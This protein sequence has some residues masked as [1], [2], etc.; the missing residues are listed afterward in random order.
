MEENN[1]KIIEKSTKSP[2]ISL[3]S[4]FCEGAETG[5]PKAPA[6]LFMN[7]KYSYGKVKKEIDSLA[8]ALKNFGIKRGEVRNS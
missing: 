5:G 4:A 7:A 6:L 2:N 1:R 3:Y 8:C